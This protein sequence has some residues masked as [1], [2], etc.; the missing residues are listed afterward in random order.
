MTT[1]PDLAVVLP[2]SGRGD[3]ATGVREGRRHLRSVPIQRTG[4]HDHD[5]LWA[6]RDTEYDDAGFSLNRFEC[7]D[8][9]A[10][11]YT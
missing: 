9:G 1:A 4:E 6:L 7:A 8:C 11:N 5:H 2:L 3:R 10:V